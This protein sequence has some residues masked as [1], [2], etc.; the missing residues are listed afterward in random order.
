MTKL[1]HPD[2]L[3]RVPEHQ[4]R[5]LL[6]GQGRCVC[7]CGDA[8]RF[9]QCKLN[10]FGDTAAILTLLMCDLPCAVLCWGG[11]APLYLEEIFNL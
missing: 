4:A 6:G 8:P 11:M 9:L 1:K 7:A 2:C 5:A 10:L 3:H